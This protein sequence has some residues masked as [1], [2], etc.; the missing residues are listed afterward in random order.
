MSN[1][2]CPRCGKQEWTQRTPRRL[3]ER[4]LRL[5]A[6]YPFQCA[7]CGHRFRVRQRRVRYVRC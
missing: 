1:P 5:A 2:P 4:L 7:G 6:I 3:W